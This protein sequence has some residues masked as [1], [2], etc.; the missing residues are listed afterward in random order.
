MGQDEWDWFR[1]YEAFGS[2]GNRYKVRGLEDLEA[3]S[4]T[5]LQGVW[6]SW[7]MALLIMG[8]GL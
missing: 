5:A 1:S 8:L 6:Y 4:I 7:D 2:M 3:R